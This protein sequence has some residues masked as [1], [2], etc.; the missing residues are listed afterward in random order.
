MR[1][2]IAFP[3]PLEIKNV[4]N[5]IQNYLRTCDLDAKWV[6]P[7]NLHITIKFLGEVS[8]SLI[9]EIKSILQGTREKLNAL[10]VSLKEFGFFPNEKNP[11]VLFIATD[12]E[13]ELKIIADYLE[14]ALSSLKFKKE[15]RFKSHITL[16]RLK[17][18]RN[19]DCILRKIKEIKLNNSFPLEQITLFKSVL[20]PHGPIYEEICQINLKR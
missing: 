18:K 9:E 2:F 19:I 1:T 17:S 6:E 3:L 11:R 14:E 16:A 7:H 13:R 8:Q 15:D 4:L 5:K 10:S 12:K 20:T